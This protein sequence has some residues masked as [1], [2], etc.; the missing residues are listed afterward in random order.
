MD[1]LKLKVHI[2]GGFSITYGEHPISLTRNRV[3]KATKLLQLLIYQGSKG[4]AE[5]RL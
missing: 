2:L 5:K 4:M 3:T 1:N